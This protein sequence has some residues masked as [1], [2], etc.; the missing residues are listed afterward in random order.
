MPDA[1]LV[2]FIKKLPLIVKNDRPKKAARGV[3]KSLCG[4]IVK[5]FNPDQNGRN[6]NIRQNLP[7][8]LRKSG[9]ISRFTMRKTV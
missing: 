8:P 7:V 5:T 9:K 3:R 6:L 4:M 2:N 1:D